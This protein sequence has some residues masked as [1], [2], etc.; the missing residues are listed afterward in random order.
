MHNFFRPLNFFFILHVTAP[1]E[2]CR[3]SHTVILTRAEDFADA[4]TVQKVVVLRWYHAP[5]DDKNV[6]DMHKMTQQ[7]A[8]Q[9]QPDLRL[10]NRMTRC[11]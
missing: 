6:T 9:Q 7:I 1:L 3:K 4:G 8:L 5:G 10:N 2:H 11:D